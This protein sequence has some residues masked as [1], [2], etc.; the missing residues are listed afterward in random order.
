MKNLQEKSE[1]LKQDYISIH[2][3]EKIVNE[4]IDYHN[5]QKTIELDSLAEKFEQELRHLK[6]TFSLKLNSEKSKN[7]NKVN[8]LTDKIETL[9]K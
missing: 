5:K 1:T 9:S 8:E 7:K 6:E 2:E 3:H 4:K